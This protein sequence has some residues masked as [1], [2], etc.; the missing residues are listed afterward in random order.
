MR[1]F[2]SDERHPLEYARPGAVR[3]VQT[4]S[5]VKHHVRLSILGAVAAIIGAAFFL[6]LTLR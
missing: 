2:V 3:Q 6:W 4:S 5:R 1:D